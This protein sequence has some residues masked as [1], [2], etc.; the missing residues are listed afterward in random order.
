MAEWTEQMWPSI[1]EGSKP[2]PSFIH[3]SL[4][5]EGVHI[6]K[7]HQEGTNNAQQPSVDWALCCLTRHSISWAV[8]TISTWP[9]RHSTPSSSDSTPCHYTGLIH[10]DHEFCRPYHRSRSGEP[11]LITVTSCPVLYHAT[12]ALVL[13]ATNA[14]NTGP[15][16]DH[17]ASAPA[18]SHFTTQQLCSHHRRTTDH[19]IL[20]NTI[21]LT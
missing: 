2:Q 1:K 3:S 17:P 12:L 21:R 11:L 10:P 13:P 19:D 20:A 15:A 8:A 5:L 4:I 9:A 6:E 7:K 14:T 18:P 16:V